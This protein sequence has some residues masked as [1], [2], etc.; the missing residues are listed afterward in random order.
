MIPF[1]IVFVIPRCNS[2][3]YN[4]SHAS[5]TTLQNQ[6]KRRNRV[7]AIRWFL[8]AVTEIVTAA[9]G[10]REAP[11]VFCVKADSKGLARR[12]GVKADSKGVAA[13]TSEVCSR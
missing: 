8:F 10:Q 4:Y 11:P 9:R 2:F 5:D 13:L 3:D 1:R 12:I 6:E 7:L